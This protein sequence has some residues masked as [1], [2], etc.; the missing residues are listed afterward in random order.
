MFSE[1]TTTAVEEAGLGG[2]DGGGGAAAAANG[3]HDVRSLHEQG[4]K[5]PEAATRRPRLRSILFASF[6]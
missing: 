1:V 2:G 4:V 3:A 5:D 6:F